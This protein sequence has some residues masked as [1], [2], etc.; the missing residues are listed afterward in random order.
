MSEEIEVG[1]KV[2]IPGIIGFLKA[3]GTVISIFEKDN[4]EMWC[5]VTLFSFIHFDF[6]LS[7]VKKV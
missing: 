5:T 4:G 2:S 7:K 6:R 3:T 1:S